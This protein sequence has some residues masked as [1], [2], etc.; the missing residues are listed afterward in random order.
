MTMGEVFKIIEK[1]EAKLITKTSF[2]T[3]NE[4]EVRIAKL[5]TS[6]EILDRVKDISTKSKAERKKSYLEI[7][8]EY[9]LS[10]G[11][12]GIYKNGKKIENPSDSMKLKAA[13]ALVGEAKRFWAREEK[14]RLK[15]V[16][17]FKEY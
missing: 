7:A 3:N 14:E 17:K 8:D 2:G 6:K 5:C 13:M 10:E 4:Y 1:K 12:G 11:L 16:S 9:I 15:R